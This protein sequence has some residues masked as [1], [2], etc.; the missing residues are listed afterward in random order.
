MKKNRQLVYLL[1]S[2]VLS[3]LVSCSSIKPYFPDKQK[4]YRYSQEIAP[5]RL[6]ADLAEQKKPEP[7]VTDLPTKTEQQDFSEESQSD[8]NI[9]Q[10][11]IPHKRGHVELVGF[12]SGAIRL[13]VYEPIKQTWYI[14]GKA[15]SREAVEVTERNQASNSYTIQFD[16]AKTEVEDG[17]LWNE[18]EF[19]FGEDKHLDQKFHILL[20]ADGQRTEIAVTDEKGIPQ[21]EGTGLGVLFMLFEA[22][23]K[24]LTESK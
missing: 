21:S 14:V 24:D 13:V 3:A 19:F 11:Q 8:E 15:L 20:A 2:L 23:K 6:P 16:P 12:D 9:R 17:S 7:L 22:I 18:V 1:I 4:D 5:L 10:S